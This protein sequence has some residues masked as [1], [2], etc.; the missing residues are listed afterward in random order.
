MSSF[1]TVYIVDDDDG[2][3][4]AMSEMVAGMNVDCRAYANAEQFL[5]HF[6]GARPACLVTDVRMSSMSGLELQEALRE[7]GLTLSIIVV[8]AYVN[9]P[10][11]VRA[12]KNGAVTVLEKPCRPYE[13]WEAIRTGLAEDELN[14]ERDARRAQ[15]QQQIES[16][17]EVEREVLDLIVEGVPN[18]TI[19]NRL[20][21]S[22]RTVEVR[23]QNIFSKLSAASLAELVQVVVEARG[24][25]L[26][27]PAE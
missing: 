5:E 10:V 25:G 19:A 2:A 24:S 15:L 9:A 23:R 14:L 22:V 21:I 27:P 13:L 8:T 4:D 26:L 7:R 12:V 18:K 1:P 6:T 16:L 20:D 17:S 11:V 3:R